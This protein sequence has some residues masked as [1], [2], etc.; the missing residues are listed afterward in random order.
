MR[1]Q[2]QV[3]GVKPSLSPPSALTPKKDDTSSQE[4]AVPGES[5]HKMT[6]GRGAKGRQAPGGTGVSVLAPCPALFF[7]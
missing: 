7:M 6:G 5:G 1:D 4:A 3:L 2:V